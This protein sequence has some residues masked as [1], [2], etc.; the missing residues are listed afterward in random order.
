[1]RYNLRRKIL[2]REKLPKADIFKVGGIKV[3]KVIVTLP[4][5]ESLLRRSI[6]G[7]SLK[8]VKVI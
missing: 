1:M 2:D 4:V 3:H 5:A 7:M 8:E 6:Y